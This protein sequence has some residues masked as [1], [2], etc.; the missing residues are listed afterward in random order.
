MPLVRAVFGEETGARAVGARLLSDGFA[1]AVVRA[2]FAGEDDDEDHAW[3]L[4]TDAP[5]VMVELLAD[6]HDGWVEHEAD[7][8]HRPDPVELPAAPRRRHRPLHGAT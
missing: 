8:A 3:A 1:A 6:E 7:P 5:E 4:E 2:A